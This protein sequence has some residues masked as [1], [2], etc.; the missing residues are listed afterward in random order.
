MSS[1]F[2]YTSNEGAI[3]IINSGCLFATHYKYLNDARELQ[4]A[5]DI[6]IPIFE[7]EFREEA[8]KLIREGKLQQDFILEYGNQVFRAE[9]TKLFDIALRTTD[10]HTPV[11]IASFCRHD[12]HSGEYQNGLLSQ[13]RGYGSSGGCAIEFDEHQL[14][15]LVEAERQKYAYTHVALADV[16]YDTYDDAVNK[17]AIEGVAAAVLRHLVDRSEETEA[18]YKERIHKVYDAIAV[19][20]PTLKT[21]GFREECEVRIVAPCMRP[22]AAEEYPDRERRPILL[23]FRNGAPVPYIRLFDGVG[24]LPIRRL[25]VGPQRDQ[26]QTAYALALALEARGMIAKVTTSKISYLPG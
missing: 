26:E 17:Q 4:L 3:G 18:A 7:A 5:R 20:S 16:R 2:H 1:I 19:V 6:I 23:R 22:S 21:P 10:N 25:V 9:A 12:L 11:F 14:L 13:W 24:Q 15:D 8:Y